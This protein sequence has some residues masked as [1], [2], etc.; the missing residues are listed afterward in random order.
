MR[1]KNVLFI[2]SEFLTDHGKLYPGGLATYTYN[3]SK[4][5]QNQGIKPTIFTLGSKTENL[6]FDSIDCII[7]RNSTYRIKKIMHIFFLGCLDRSVSRILESFI[8][9]WGAIK[10]YKK[11]DVVHFT[12]W[13]YPGLF[14]PKLRNGVVRISSY[15]KYMYDCSEKRDLDNWL[16]QKLEKLEIKKFS[17]I[18][19]PGKMIL[20]E[21]N[22]SLNKRCAV[23]PTPFIPS[24]NLPKEIVKISMNF[25]FVGSLSYVKGIDLLFELVNLV[26]DKYSDAQ[27]CIVGKISIVN[28]DLILNKINILKERFGSRF[29]Y[30]GALK[31]DDL[32]VLYRKSE[33]VIIPSVYDNF[34]NVALEAMAN[35]CIVIASNTSSLDTLITAGENG[36]I[37]ENRTIESWAIIID[38]IVQM[39]PEEKSTIKKRIRDK[40]SYYEPENAGKL[41]IDYYNQILS[42]NVL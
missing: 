9:Y 40:L 8:I 29:G 22:L 42:N 17:Y 7:F 35:E 28:S 32:N 5:L 18:I 41:L 30:I 6:K 23:I 4:I 16:N 13:K 24:Q 15:E 31:R 33:I 39:T 27:F 26:L 1:C 3:I 21:I 12:N 37:V 19:G 38:S 20:D 11:F 36:F 2:T 25:L 34:P 14:F 10:V